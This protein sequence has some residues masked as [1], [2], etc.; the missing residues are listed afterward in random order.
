MST[1]ILVPVGIYP[2]ILLIFKVSIAFEVVKEV[3]MIVAVVEE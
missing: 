3:P 1:L 2:T